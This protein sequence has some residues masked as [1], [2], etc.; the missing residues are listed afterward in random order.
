[1]VQQ[2]FPLCSLHLPDFK[3]LFKL[4]LVW[5]VIDWDVFLAW[6][7]FALATRVQ[8]LKQTNSHHTS[9]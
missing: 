3:T 1:M 9:R 4:P 7:F 5:S 2:D 8:E 6:H